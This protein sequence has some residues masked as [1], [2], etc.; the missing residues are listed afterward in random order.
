MPATTNLKPLIDALAE[1]L[2][3]QVAAHEQLAETLTRQREAMARGDARLMHGLAKLQ[4]ETL[5]QIQT[6]DQLRARTAQKLTGFLDPDATEPLRLAELADR[7][8]EPDRG[9]LRV[10][11][12]RLTDQVESARRTTAV[13]HTAAASLANHVGCILQN[14]QHRRSGGSAYAPSGRSA[15]LRVPGGLSLSA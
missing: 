12:T 10:L 2:N 4:R 15:A 5:Q 11:R 13:N 3:R 1:T 6:L 8:P 9:R 7:L 14:V